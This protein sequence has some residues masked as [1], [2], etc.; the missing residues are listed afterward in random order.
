M[1]VLDGAT[2]EDI[3][4][5]QIADG[6]DPFAEYFSPDVSSPQN[7]SFLFLPAPF[8]EL[9]NNGQH[10]DYL[11]FSSDS[12]PTWGFGLIEGG[13]IGGMTGVLPTPMPVPE[14]MSIVMLGAG[15]LIGFIRRRR[16]SV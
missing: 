13:A 8:G 11:L 9:I 14:P 6:I 15:G 7:A 5:D 12:E 10:S 3:Y 2:V 16:R 1:C 4:V